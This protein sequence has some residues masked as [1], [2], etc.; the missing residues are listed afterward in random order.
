M[1]AKIIRS[2]TTRGWGE[3]SD[4][5]TPVLSSCG[6]SYHRSGVIWGHTPTL[7]RCAEDFQNRITSI[8]ELLWAL[9]ASEM[10]F[11][12]ALEKGKNVEF[13]V[14]LMLRPV[15][16]PS[17][18]I[19][20]S[21]RLIQPQWPLCVVFLRSGNRSYWGGTSRRDNIPLPKPRSV[22]QGTV[23]WFNQTKGFGFIERE[24]G[25]DLFVHIS[26]V[27]GEIQDGDTV[28]FEVGEGPKGPNAVGVRKV[29][30]NSITYFDGRQRSAKFMN[31]SLFIIQTTPPSDWKEFD[32]EPFQNNW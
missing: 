20:H 25:N 15:S 13:K 29:E 3:K 31:G 28:E 7:H 14:F 30:W 12:D 22:A 24:G 1:C 18:R 11:A 32:V 9:F 6:V 4:S 23:K 17:S 27:E 10:L 2:R 19:P 8:V 26:E 16:R 21:K 5:S